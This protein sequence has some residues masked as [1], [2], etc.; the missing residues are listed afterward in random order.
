MENKNID[1]PIEANKKKWR[2][3]ISYFRWYPDKFL[4]FIKQPDSKISLYVYQR[5]Y[6]RIMM[7][8]RKVFITATRG[9]SKSYL[10]N[11]CFIL[12]CIFYP[13]IRLF[14]TCSGKAQAAQ[15]SQQCIEDI[16][17]H[18][19]FLKGEIDWK[20]TKFEK[21]YTRL[22]FHNGSKYDVVQMSDSSRGGR[23]HGKYCVAVYKHGEPI[24]IGC[25]TN[26]LV[27]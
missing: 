25:I 10:Q 22:V 18:Y 5:I 4:D 11:L 23:R 16:L 12:K 14:V 6:L 24:S 17:D 26:E 21:D 7:R 3:L 1:N 13:R 2:M 9:T 15:I 19:P 27:A 8:Y 20:H